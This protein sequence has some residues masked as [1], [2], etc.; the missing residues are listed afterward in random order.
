MGG[1]V[2]GAAG[3]TMRSMRLGIHLNAE[4]GTRQGELFLLTVQ[5]LQWKLLSVC[6]PAGKGTDPNLY[7]Q[8]I[9][10]VW[11]GRSLCQ[12]DDEWAAKVGL[13]LKLEAGPEEGSLLWLEKSERAQADCRRRSQATSCSSHTWD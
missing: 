10:G 13:K 4:G 3:R 9:C 2:D 1:L 11:D 12:R 6:F 7:L 5:I 8:A